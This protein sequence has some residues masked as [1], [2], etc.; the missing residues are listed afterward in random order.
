MDL[1]ALH[2]RLI[3]AARTD[4]PSD[5]VP[6]AFEKR[7]MANLGRRKPDRLEYWAHSLWRAVAPCAAVALLLGVWSAATPADASGTE[8]FAQHFESTLLADSAAEPVVD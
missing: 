7:V 4:V 8:E 2:K 1:A 3:A 5:A 6:Y